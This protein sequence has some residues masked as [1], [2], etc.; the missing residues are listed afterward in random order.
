MP[1]HFDSSEIEIL[2]A[3]NINLT[4]PSTSW[5]F[6]GFS[7]YL[8]PYFTSSSSCIFLWNITV[9]IHVIIFLPNASTVPGIVE[10]KKNVL[11]MKQWVNS[12]AR[13]GNFKKNSLQEN[14]RK[15]VRLLWNLLTSQI[16]SSFCEITTFLSFSLLEYF[17]EFS[18]SLLSSPDYSL[19]FTTEHYIYFQVHSR[20]T[21]EISQ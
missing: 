16:T 12:K 1:L 14:I 6:S 13:S 11:W 3:L 20:A 18:D 8:A 17:S 15:L 5:G 7:Q 21:L 4:L 2:P 19:I 9:S 10:H